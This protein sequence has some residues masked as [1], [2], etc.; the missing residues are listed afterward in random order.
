MAVIRDITED[1]NYDLSIPEGS[2]QAYELNSEAYD[3]AFNDQ[4][5]ILGPTDERPYRR[6]TAEYRR[7]QID[8]T[9]EPGEQSL[10]GWWFRSQSSFHLGSGAKFFEPSQEESLRFRFQ[11][12]EGVDVWNRGELSLLKDTVR[13]LQTANEV[14]I[15]SAN[16]GTDDCLIVADGPELKKITMANDTPTV[17]NYTLGNGHTNEVF[18]SLTTDGSR[19]FAADNVAIHRGNIGGTTSDATTYAT[20]TDEVVINFV[21]QRLFAGVGNALY[22]LDPNASPL[23]NH[24]TTA[25][26]TAHY[27]HPNVNWKWTSI[28]ESGSAIYASGFA[29]NTSAIYKV[30][31]KEDATL[32]AA[33][34]TAELPI[35]ERV[36]SLYSY[37]GYIIFGT[38]KGA[39]V[40][41]VEPDTGNLSYGPL[42]FE[43]PLGVNSF[44]AADRFVWCAANVNGKTGLI[45]IDLGEQVSPLRFAYSNDIY[46]DEQNLTKAVSIIDGRPAFCADGDGIYI[47]SKDTLV[48]NGYIQTGFIRYATLESKFFKFIKLRGNLQNGTITVASISEKEIEDT[49]LDFTAA[50]VDTDIGIARPQGAQEFVGFKFTLNRNVNDNTKGAIMTGYQIKALPAIEKQTLIQYPLYCYDI[51]MDRFNVQTGYDGRAYERV[52]KFESLEKTGDVVVVRDFRTNEAFQGLI[53]DTKFFSQTPPDSRFNGFGGVLL[54]TVRK[55]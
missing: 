29:G 2:I 4:P 15:V 1:F 50:L 28:S 32:A 6:E 23:G 47:E 16:D 18:H 45:R 42:I 14:N 7:Q 46:V 27:T 37:L 11:D 26:P 3:I 49:L 51:E 43:A 24:T 22:E 54:V 33:V 10:T 12:S 35:G 39:R 53:E 40:A 34:V 36:L 21:K 20:G 9:T 48:E 13:V 44:F 5:F 25:L 8:Q 17:T 19:Y 31:V 55:F 38:S 30:T 52:L 41:I